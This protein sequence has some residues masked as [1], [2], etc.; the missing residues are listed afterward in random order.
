MVEEKDERFDT[1]AKWIC[2]RIHRA[3]M[4]LPVDVKKHTQEIRLRINQPVCISCA[5]GTYFLGTNGELTCRP[6]NGSLVAEPKDMED[7]FR[8]LCSYS[9]Y[10]HENEIKN[11]YITL[12]GGHRAGLCGTAV[13]QS[14]TICSIRNISSINLRISREIPGA[15]DELLN[16][17]GKSLNEGLL[18]AGAPSSGK[19]TILRD[20]ARQMSSGLRGNLKKVSVIDERG[21]IAGTYMGIPQNDL[22]C[23]CDVLDGYPKAEGILLA[24]RTLSPQIVICDEIGSAS[25]VNAVEEGLNTGVTMIASIH[26]GSIDELMRRKQAQKLLRTGAF[27]NV[28]V[29]DATHG[30]GQI[31]GIYKAGDLVDKASWSPSAD[32]GWKSFGL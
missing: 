25:E 5:E 10:S 16:Q 8:N 17:L 12:S 26:A 24:V 18:L 2:E 19:T 6:T 22:G 21:E 1:A 28:A 11:G 3:L 4:N 30:P 31:A 29:L 7:S 23:C 20:I 14:S 32:Y 15:A 9:I 27:G 13:I